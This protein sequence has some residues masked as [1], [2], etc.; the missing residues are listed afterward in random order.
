MEQRNKVQHQKYKHS[1]APNRR[2]TVR[3]NHEL[4]WYC[5]KHKQ[6]KRR[7]TFCDKMS[8]TEPIKFW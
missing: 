8:G 5:M 4:N 1:W 6:N 7:N 3:M 2:I